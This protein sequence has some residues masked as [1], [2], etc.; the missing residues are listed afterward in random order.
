MAGTD[1]ASFDVLGVPVSV[2]TPET[3]LNTIVA[4]ASD[5]TGRYVCIR[6]V[7][8]VMR[9][10]DD[11]ELLDIHRRAAMVT[12]D[13]MPLALIGK[14]RGLPVER[15]TGPDL[16]LAAMARP[17]LRHYLY[18]GG[19]GVAQLLETRLRSLPTDPLIVGL[20]T[21]PFR[22]ETDD[23]LD[24]L[25]ARIRA[26]NAN[27]VWIGLSTPKQERVM[28]RLA[29]LTGATLIGVGAAFD[30]HAGLMKRPPR[31]V[32]R[33]SLEGVYRFCKEPRRLWYRYLVLAPRFAALAA[34][35]EWRRA[36]R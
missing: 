28:A 1:I 24:A 36:R 5:E 13:G 29:P 26:S 20:E 14:R 27:T 22:A 23:E 10:Q 4:W 3:A 11:A 32:Q 17:E 6:D 21:P 18:G 34:R 31:W 16:M 7:H 2:V 9:A 25:A 12:P 19:S 8:G 35:E 15:T 33:S 30:I